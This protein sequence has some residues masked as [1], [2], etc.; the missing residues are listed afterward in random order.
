ME[1]LIKFNL[2]MTPALPSNMRLGYKSAFTSSYSK[3]SFMALVAIKALA[4]GQY[5]QTGAKTITFFAAVV[6]SAV[7]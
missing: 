6:N 3:K 1:H 7:S 4:S 2:V 5:G